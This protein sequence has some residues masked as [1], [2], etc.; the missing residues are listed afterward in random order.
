MYPPRVTLFDYGAGN[1]HSLAKA[2]EHAG[3]AVRIEADAAAAVRDTD[4]LVLPGVG[5]FAAAAERLAPGR[6][7][8]RDAIAAGL[9]TLGICLGMQLMFDGSDEGPG[10]GLGLIPGRVTRIQAQRVPQIGWNTVEPTGGAPD[11][12]LAVSGLTIA[13]YA[14][15]FVCRPE[16]ADASVVAWSEHEGDRFPAAVRAAR[17]VGVQFH[18]EKS[19]APGVAMIDAFVR[20]L[21]TPAST[22][23]GPDR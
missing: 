1:L 3:A 22:S 16:D 4:A 21:N 14:N 2:L 7:A 8:M 9:P 18:P 23:S 17:A 11:P 15:S 10:E 13:Y 6:E 5:A 19:S 12:L 20:S